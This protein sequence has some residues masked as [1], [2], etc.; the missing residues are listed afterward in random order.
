MKAGIRGGTL[1][2][3][4]RHKERYHSVHINTGIRSRTLVQIRR[5]KERDQMKTSGILLQVMTR[6]RRGS[7]DSR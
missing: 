4:K 6:V 2:R 1:V 3:M 5:H 7:L